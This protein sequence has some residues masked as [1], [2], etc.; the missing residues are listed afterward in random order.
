MMNTKF[1]SV[2]LV[3]IAAAMLGACTRSPEPVATS[4]AASIDNAALA[5]DKDGK[6]WP[7]YGRTFGEGHFSPL[8][9]INADTVKRLGLAWSLD[10]DVNNSITAPLAVDGVIYLGAGHGVVHA[11]DAKSG[12]LLWRFDAKA[13]EAAGKKLRTAWGIR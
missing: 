8:T 10:L 4:P 11:V 7:A 12:K 6:N 2:F 1:R 9:E 13:P 5:N 3:S